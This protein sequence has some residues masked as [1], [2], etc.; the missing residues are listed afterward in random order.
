MRTSKLIFIYVLDY[1]KQVEFGN[2]SFEGGCNSEFM[3]FLLLQLRHLCSYAQIL[4]K[5][6]IYVMSYGKQPL[7]DFRSIPTEG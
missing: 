4:T 7:L 6:H 2:I 1:G 5:F 3:K